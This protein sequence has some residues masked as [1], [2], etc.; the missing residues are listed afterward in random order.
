MLVLASASPRRHELLNN[1]A[2]PF[3]A[4]PADLDETPLSGEAPRVLAERL[5]QE[6]ARAV[7]RSRPRDWVL[8]ADTVVVVDEV[9][10]GKPRD[11][12]E[13]AHMLQL[14]SGRTHH[15]ITGV[16][17]ISPTIFASA[18]PQEDVRSEMTTVTMQKL[19]DDEIRAYVVTGDSLDK[20]GGYGIQGVASRWV[21]RIEGDYCNV[22]GLPV[23]LVYT[24]LRAAGAL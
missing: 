10:L 22:M 14:L 4:Q 20:A 17:V 11:S 19:S 8:G 7:H 12:A 24:M 16:C 1:A 23:S 13:A 2:I 3:I 21:P 9:M 18:K 6:K 15:V 5:A